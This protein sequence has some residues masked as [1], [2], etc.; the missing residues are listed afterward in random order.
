MEN[1]KKNLQN[2]KKLIFI[3]VVL[4]GFQLFI[5]ISCTINPNVITQGD[6]MAESKLG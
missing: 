1:V 3:Y 6:C 5:N 4:M 2:F